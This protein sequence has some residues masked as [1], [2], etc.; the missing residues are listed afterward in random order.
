MYWIAFERDAYDFLE[1][2]YGPV[3]TTRPVDEAVPRVASQTVH[4]CWKGARFINSIT[5]EWRATRTAAPRHSEWRHAACNSDVLKTWSFK[6]AANYYGRVVIDAAVVDGR[7]ATPIPADSYHQKQPTP[8]L[9]CSRCQR[10][11]Q[12]SRLRRLRGWPSTKTAKRASLGR[13]G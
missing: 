8:P 10:R 12:G 9:S 6:P 11:N 1:P 4:K 7:N 2:T 13:G 5:S 3:F